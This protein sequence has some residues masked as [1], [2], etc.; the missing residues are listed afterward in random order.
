MQPKIK[1]EVVKDRSFDPH[2]HVKVHYEADGVQLA[3][4]PVSVVRRAPK[5]TFDHPPE[6]LEHLSEEAR[7]KL[8]LEIMNRI[9]EHI[10]HHAE[11]TNVTARDTRRFL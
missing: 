1:V 2:F 7:R 10:M 9:L 5:V 3:G 6:I 4:V 8:E 11:Q